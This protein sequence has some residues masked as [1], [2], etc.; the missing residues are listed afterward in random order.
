MDKIANN[1]NAM[2]IVYIPDHVID[3]EHER[4]AAGRFLDFDEDNLRQIEFGFIM[5]TRYE[6][7]SMGYVRPVSAYC[8]LWRSYQSK[9]LRTRANSELARWDNIFFFDS[10]PQAQVD[11][12]IRQIEEEIW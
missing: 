5:S 7:D 3:L 10:V 6:D 4:I 1:Y 2:Q 9:E 8:R 11:A 12:A